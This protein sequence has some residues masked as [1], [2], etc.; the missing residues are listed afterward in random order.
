MIAETQGIVLNYIKYKETSIIVKI[1][2]QKFGLK[3]FI[4]NGIRSKKAKRSIGLFQPLT[5]LEIQLYYYEN[6][7]L[8]R[9]SDAKISQATPVIS[10][11]IIKS[12]LALFVTEV[13]GKTLTHE[14][15]ENNQLY[16]FLRDSVLILDA[17][18]KNIE[19]FHLLFLIE[20]SVFLGL[21][22]MDPEQIELVQL[23]NSEKDYLEL[24]IS[25]SYDDLN[26]LQ[27]SL[28][29]GSSRK[30]CLEAILSYFNHHLGNMIEIKSL[31]VLH[32]IFH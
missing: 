30:A 8:L 1:Y 21:D 27:T 3:S 18:E 23:S 11:N 19:D 15:H 2:T 24:L 9:L 10:Q 32:R 22:L 28:I 26:T 5:L 14:H 6:R 17:L 25:Y 20:Y 31:K 7:E 16:Q 4:V 13:L 29:S 12:T